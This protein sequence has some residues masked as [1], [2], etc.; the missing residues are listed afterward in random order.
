MEKIKLIGEFKTEKQ[1]NRAFNEAY[2]KAGWIVYKVEDVGYGQKW[3]DDMLIKNGERYD[4]EL[5]VISS[6]TISLNSRDSSPAGDFEFSQLILMER[7]IEFG[8]S[9]QIAM[10]SKKHKDYKIIPFDTLRKM[11]RVDGTNRVKLF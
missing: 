4:V 11:E 2:R 7:L 1:F 3:L 8:Q 6:D 5:K 9:P 10:W